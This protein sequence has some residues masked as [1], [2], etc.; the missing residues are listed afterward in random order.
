MLG[1]SKMDSS[2]FVDTFGTDCFGIETM[3]SY[4]SKTVYKSLLATMN[5]GQPI[6]ES[7]ADEVANA[8]KQWAMEKGA[9]HFTHWFQPMT[10]STAEKHDSFFTPDFKGGLIAAF[11]GKTL[12]QG[13]P[14]AS[15]FPNGGIRQTCEARGYTAWDPTS[16]AFLKKTDKSCTLCIPTAFLSYT[17]EALD[18]KTP[19]LRS[20]RAVSDQSK[21]IL[22]HFGVEVDGMVQ[23]TLGA[24]QEYFLI[25]KSL[26]LERPDLIQ[27]GRTLFGNTPARHQQLDDHYFGSIKSRIADFMAELDQELW[28]VGVP[29]LTRHNEVAPGQFELAP[30]FQYLNVSVDQNM[31]IM[32]TMKRLANEY[33]LVCLL[34]E[35][36]FAGINGSGKHNNWSMSANGKNLLDPGATPH[37]N[38][39]FLTLLCAIIKAVDSYPELM[40]AAVASAG[41]DH[42]LG[43]NEAPPAILSIFLGETLMNVVEQIAAGSTLSSKD[44]GKMCLGVD[45][46][47]QLAKD[48]TDRNR[49]SPF[50]FTGNRFEFRA[51]GSEQ[52]C[53]GPN[54][55]LNSIVAEALSDIADEMDKFSG[56]FNT[57]LAT[58]LQKVVKDHVKVCYNGDGYNEDAWING[59]SKKR[60]LPELKTTKEALEALKDK[61]AVDVMSKFGVYSPTEL[62]ARYEILTEQYLTKITIEADLALDM[63]KTMILPAAMDQQSAL[64]D[65]ILKLADAGIEAGASTQK[66]LAEKI[67][68]QIDAICDGCC[69]LSSAIEAEDTVA[70]KAGMDAVRVAGDALE[71]LVDSDIWPMPKYSDLLYKY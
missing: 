69:K 45:L 44:G 10:G 7:V 29:A 27:T 2:K 38:A 55:I 53:A 6:D 8:M 35:K 37:D 5:N 46:L 1:E 9:T 51:V 24:E 31:I 15:S 20:M 16:P 26:Y 54:I 17:G 43:A 14:D 19:L 4:V 13:E 58:L 49:T 50:A 71:L 42:R 64:V 41:N 70:M 67:G 21:R 48:N 36:P 3:R 30:T 52:N 34:H 39:Q 25:D 68:T 56:D 12:V 63:A 65:N 28:K 32:D 22:S 57:E 18:K 33:D 11:S 60:G 40:R 66:K 59:E 61:K 47:P 62:E 23:T